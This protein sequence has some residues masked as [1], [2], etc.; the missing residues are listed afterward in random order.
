MK[1]TIAA[2]LLAIRYVYVN[3]CHGLTLMLNE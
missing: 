3:A 1:I 2:G